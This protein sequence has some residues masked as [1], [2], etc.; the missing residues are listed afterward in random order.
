[1]E[2]PQLPEP[3]EERYLDLRCAGTDRK[4]TPIDGLTRCWRNLSTWGIHPVKL[5]AS[6]G[7][8]CRGSGEGCDA[9][10]ATRTGFHLPGIDA[11]GRRGNRCGRCSRGRR[12]GAERGRLFSG[13]A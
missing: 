12:G 13:R 3:V 1:E 10:L 9:W 7:A 4:T 6:S 2:A 11:A 5:P 8:L